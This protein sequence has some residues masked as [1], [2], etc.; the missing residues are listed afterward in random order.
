MK[1][2]LSTENANNIQFKTE[3]VNGACTVVKPYMCVNPDWE[4][5]YLLN[6]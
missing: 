2:T 6:C 3:K 5:E 1:S 4:E